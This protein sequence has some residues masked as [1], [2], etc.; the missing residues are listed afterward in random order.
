MKYGMNEDE[1]EDT[2]KIFLRQ[3][4]HYPNVVKHSFFH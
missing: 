3:L 4:M 1:D 2:G